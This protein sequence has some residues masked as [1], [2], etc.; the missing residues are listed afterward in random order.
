M[1]DTNLPTVSEALG[2]FQ[3]TLSERGQGK[4]TP[5]VIDK[6]FATIAY[7]EDLSGAKLGR[8]SNVTK[9]TANRYIR[10]DVF[11]KLNVAVRMLAKLGYDLYL[12]KRED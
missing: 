12:V 7:Q 8:I 10:G 3:S 2:H 5:E 9:V 11:P 6:M 4:L 1:N